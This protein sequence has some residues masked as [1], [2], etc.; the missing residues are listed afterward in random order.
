MF[1][2][3]DLRPDTDLIILD[4]L[5][6]F[7]CHFGD[8]SVLEYLT[9]PHL[10]RLDISKIRE[11]EHVTIFS[12]F[13]RRSACHLQFLT[14]RDTA[15]I[16][17]SILFAFLRAVPDSTSDVEFVWHQLGSTEHLF[18]ALQSMDILPELKHLRLRA[19]AR[20]NDE[21]YHNLLEMLH[22]RVEARPPRVP[23]Q[24]LALQLTIPHRWN[25]KAKPCSSRVAQPRELV[26]AGLKINF[27]ITTSST[28]THAGLNLRA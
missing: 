20:M 1:P 25:A 11:P 5:E 2:P 14:V 27:K 6:T 26:S 22:A 8:A 12:A 19:R 24:S 9:L 4:S 18:S 21:E 23:L 28:S 15:M 16:S 13:I 7:T 3:L 10:S 17:S